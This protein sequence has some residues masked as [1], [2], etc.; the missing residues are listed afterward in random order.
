MF[1]SK[2]ESCVV[3]EDEVDFF[4]KQIMKNKNNEYPKKSIN[5]ENLST[6]SVCRW[7]A[8]KDAIDI[9]ADKCEDKKVNFETFDIKPLDILKYVDRATDDLYNKVLSQEVENV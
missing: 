2:I 1:Q 8:L 5:I 6:Y 3:L 7:M 9:I 4:S